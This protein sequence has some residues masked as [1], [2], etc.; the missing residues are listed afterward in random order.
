[1]FA[2]KPYIAA[3]MW[4]ALQDF[5]ARPGW[6]GGDPFPHPPFVEKG[7][8]D[9]QGNP[10][11]PLF[12]TIQSIYTSTV[13]IGPAPAPARRRAKPK[14]SGR[15]TGSAAASRSPGTHPGL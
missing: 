10:V 13:Q 15:R 4:F 7:E 11:Q 14:R 12:G 5:P 9:L 1:V 8:I 2:S 3:A 6:S